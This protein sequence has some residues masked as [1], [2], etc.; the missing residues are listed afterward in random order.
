VTGTS[1][2]FPNHLS[3]I[4]ISDIVHVVSLLTDC[5]ASEQFSSNDSPSWDKL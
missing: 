1:P 3:D 2:A 5:R 4:S